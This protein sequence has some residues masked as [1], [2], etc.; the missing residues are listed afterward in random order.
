[1]VSHCKS[2][3]QEISEERKLI[4]KGKNKESYHIKNH[5]K[6][7]KITEIDKI[8]Y[9]SPIFRT[10]NRPHPVPISDS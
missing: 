10:S 7:R 1:M 9:S 4:P 5:K 3:P 8:T 2:L 6:A